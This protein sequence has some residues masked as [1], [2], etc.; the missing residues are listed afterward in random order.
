MKTWSPGWTSCTLTQHPVYC[1]EQLH[2]TG[3][4]R[5]WGTRCCLL[6]RGLSAPPH[7]SSCLQLHLM[8]SASPENETTSYFRLSYMLGLHSIPQQRGCALSRLSRWW[9]TCSNPVVLPVGN[10]TGQRYVPPQKHAGAAGS[11]SR[12]STSHR[13]AAKRAGRQQWYRQ[14]GR[15]TG[16]AMLGRTAREHASGPVLQQNHHV[17]STAFLAREQRSL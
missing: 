11:S 8:E 2:C 9:I 12:S 15:S 14:G 4:V 17:R 13:E 10:S 7:P 3:N 5:R 6:Q 16:S 1:S